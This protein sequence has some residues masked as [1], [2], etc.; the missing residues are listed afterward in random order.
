M[1]TLIGLFTGS[2]EVRI[3]LGIMSVSLYAFHYC[4]FSEYDQYFLTCIPVIRSY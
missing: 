4:S 3:A 2:A 1:I